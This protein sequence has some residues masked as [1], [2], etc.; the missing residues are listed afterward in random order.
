MAS[1]K[2]F[3]TRTS[4]TPRSEQVTI[5]PYR[6]IGNPGERGVKQPQTD[7][8]VPNSITHVPNGGSK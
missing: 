1:D 6:G 7:I 4:M 2:I 3:N 5:D 8:P